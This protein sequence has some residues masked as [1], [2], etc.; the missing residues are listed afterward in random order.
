MLMASSNL[1]ERAL[2]APRAL[3]ASLATEPIVSCCDAARLFVFFFFRE[4][5]RARP[6]FFGSTSGKMVAA[7]LP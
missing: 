4:R 6:V 1:R 7:N 2:P 3:L 5:C